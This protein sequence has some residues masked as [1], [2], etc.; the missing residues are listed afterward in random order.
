MLTLPSKDP[1]DPNFRRLTYVRY[2]DDWIIGIRGSKRE[3]VEILEKVKVYLS[4][5]LKLT[6]SLEK[7]VIT[8][9]SYEAALFLGTRLKRASHTSHHRSRGPIR[10]N[11]REIRL[12]APKDRIQRKLHEAGFLKGG[13]PNPRFI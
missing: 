7:T 11:S 5:E 10:R 12:E 13:K 2:A 8:N 4:S 6:L 9:A 1:S 3:C